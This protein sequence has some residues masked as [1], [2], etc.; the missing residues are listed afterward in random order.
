ML[1]SF[2]S[3]YVEDD[4]N[5]H[6]SVSPVLVLLLLKADAPDAAPAHWC[7]PCLAWHRCSLLA[8]HQAIISCRLLH[9]LRL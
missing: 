2:K 7:G 6:Y 3:L 1:H 4:S 9:V 5:H 8:C